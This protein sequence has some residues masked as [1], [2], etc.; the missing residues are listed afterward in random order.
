MFNNSVL[1][2]EVNNYAILDG[3]ITLTYIDNLKVIN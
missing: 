3:N 1:Y 2:K